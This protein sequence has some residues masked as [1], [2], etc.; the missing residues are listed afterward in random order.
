MLV[1]VG[2]LRITWSLEETP[3]TVFAWSEHCAEV[4]FEPGVMVKLPVRPNVGLLQADPEV[5]EASA[6]WAVLTAPLAIFAEVTALAWMLT[7]ATASLPQVEESRRSR[8]CHRDLGRG[9]RA[10]L[11][12]GGGDRFASTGGGQ[13]GA[14]DRPFAIFAEVT[15]SA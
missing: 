7:V 13:I 6:T 2:P 9:H 12:V 3:L 4:M 15:A 8:S 14:R 11:D 10:G 1:P 5:V